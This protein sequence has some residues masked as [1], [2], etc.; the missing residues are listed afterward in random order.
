[1]K[2]YLSLSNCITV[3]YMSPTNKLGAR[4]RLST[5]DLS[6]YNNKK[7]CRKY[8]N[9]D[10]SCN[11]ADDQAQ[12]YFKKLGLKIHGYNSRGNESIYLFKWDIETMAKIFGYEK[13]VCH[14]T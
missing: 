6:H 3:K 1:M 5:Y 2:K 11:Y 8:L 10:H 9:Y 13:E 14:D 7:P 12:K 4:I